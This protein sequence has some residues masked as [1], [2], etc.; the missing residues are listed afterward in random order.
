MLLSAAIGQ[1]AA[2]G[3]DAV[4]VR[5]IAACAGVDAAMIV[6]H[7]GSK[8]LL[9]QAA[10]DQLSAQMLGA[11]K[12]LTL[13]APTEMNVG[14]RMDQA[15]GQIVD[16]LCDTPALSAFVLRE[17]VL[18]NDRSD[19]SYERLVKPIHDRLRP[20]IVEYS[21]PQG[22]VDADYLF[23]ALTGA[24]VSTIAARRLFDRISGE[25]QDDRE[26]RNLL[27]NTVSAQLAVRVGRA[28]GST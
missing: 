14:Q 27:K 10:I 4:G 28:R 22:S 16:M 12:N 18:E 21:R 15:V 25:P 5:Q 6:H 1:F 8:L 7:F 13:D 11:L 24:V 26:F 17:I 2:Q 19:Y 20:L 23:I 9:W 3:Y